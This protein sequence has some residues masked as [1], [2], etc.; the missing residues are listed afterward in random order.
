MHGRTGK[1]KAAKPKFCAMTCGATKPKG[2]DTRIAPLAP[3]N[4]RRTCEA[5]QN[6]VT[7]LADAADYADARRRP[8]RRRARICSRRSMLK[9]AAAAAATSSRLGGRPLCGYL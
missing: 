3:S 5:V 8:S 1:R 7:A 9:C 6:L 4:Y 2:S